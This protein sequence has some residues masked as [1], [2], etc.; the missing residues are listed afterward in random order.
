MAR[1]LGINLPIVSKFVDTGVKEAKGAFGGLG[2]SLGKLGGIIATAFSVTAIT[3]FAKESI[4]AAEG[5]AVA[6]QRIDQI[7]KSMGIFGAQT[8]EVSDRLK[9]YAEANELTVGVDA[10]V[11]KATQAKLLAFKGLASTADEAGGAFDRT[12]KAALDLAAA[13]FGSAEANAAKLGRALEDPIKGM[14]ALARSGVV[15]T[16]AEKEK[17]KTLVKSGDTLAAQNL[18]LQ[19]L[20]TRFGGTAAATA[21]ASERIKLAFDNVRES[22]GAQLLPVF[23]TFQEAL[24]PLIEYILPVFTGFLEEKIVPFAQRAADAFKNFTSEIKQNG[25]SIGELFSSIIEGIVGFIEGGGL[26]RI[27]EQIAETRQAFFQAFTK[28]LP[29]LLQALVEFLPHLIGFFVQLVPLLLREIAAIVKELAKALVALLPVIIEVLL[30]ALPDLLDAAIEFFMALVDALDEILPDLID[31]LIDLIP[32]IVDTLLAAMPKLIVAGFELFMGLVEGL[33]EATPKIIQGVVNLIPKIVD[34]LMENMPKILDAGFQIVKGLAQGIIE[35]APKILADAAKNMGNTLINGVKDLLGIRSPSK[36]FYGFGMAV[37]QG[38]IDGMRVMFNGVAATAEQLAAL[39][40]DPT[41]D[42]LAKLGISNIYTMQAPGAMSVQT[43]RGQMFDVAQATYDL[44]AIY[45]Y[46][47]AR[48]LE[49]MEEVQRF[50]FGG[51]FQQA[52]DSL[53]G[54]TSLENAFTGE[55]RSIAGTAEGIKSVIE[56]MTD[57]FYYNVLEPLNVDT[58][59]ESF[60]NLRRAVEE[61]GMVPTALRVSGGGSGGG[62]GGDVSM[63]LATGGLVTQPVRALVGEAGPEVVMPLDRFES[64]Y[65]LDKKAAVAPT[66]NIT[67]NAGMGADGT[68]LGRTIVDEILKFERSSGRV[69]ARA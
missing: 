26:E 5:V 17:I 59:V 22:V 23:N 53:F 58:V 52:L 27:F 42:T 11:I 33:I 1:G 31:A 63:A 61:G 45:D 32:K 66:Y 2:K 51:T 47:D 65:G 69:F 24:L 55:I 34:S 60:D 54:Q 57:A 62:G 29:G 18:I 3:N 15:F 30:D 43:V 44:N 46:M 16:D 19:A 9:E 39:A 36:V 41:A 12:T 4:A 7:A 21:T 64:L 28:A 56:N 48:T 38:F 37:G 10:E 50:L 14:S 20:E 6:N 25:F 13:G 8:Q 35:N 67:V 68:Q 49:Q 40:A